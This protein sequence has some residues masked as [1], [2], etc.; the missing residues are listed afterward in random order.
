MTESLM[1]YLPPIARQPQSIP[2]HGAAKYV[3][4]VASGYDGKR[5][6]DPK[7]TIE[8]QIIEGWINELPDGSTVL[9]APAGTGRWLGIFARKKLDAYCLDR[10]EDMLNQAMAKA[11]A[12]GYVAQF[13]VGNVLQVPLGDKSVD[14]CLNIRISRWLSPDENQQMFREMQR[15]SRG[16]IVWTARV[17]NH[18]HSRTRELYEAALTPGWAITRDV[19]GHEE[20]YRIMM[21]ERLAP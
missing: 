2:Q 17:A 1:H 15:L 14:L 9:D 6:N 20:P 3:G 5:A 18:V 4:A 19:E 21:A 16:K 8:Q 12:L 13:G 11:N 10:S 7:W